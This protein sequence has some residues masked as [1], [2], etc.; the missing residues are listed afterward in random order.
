MS[1]GFEALVVDSAGQDLA[2]HFPAT[3]TV[4]KIQTFLSAW[5]GVGLKGINQLTDMA[6]SKAPAAGEFDL[7]ERVLITGVGDGQPFRFMLI[8][9]T[10][11][12]VIV[13]GEGRRLSEEDCAAVGG[14]L[15]EAY[16]LTTLTITEGVWLDID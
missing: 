9:P 15:R 1:S 10:Y 3:S 4:S 16:G 2:I 13:E 12:P 14:M 11:T 6:Y 5:S 7:Q 8:A